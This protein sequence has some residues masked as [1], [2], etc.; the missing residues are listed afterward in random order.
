[1]DTF[2]TVQL[3]GMWFND[4]EVEFEIEDFGDEKYNCITVYECKKEEK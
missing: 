2:V 3:R 1:M 4:A